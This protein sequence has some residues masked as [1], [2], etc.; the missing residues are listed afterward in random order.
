LPES[1]SNELI[2]IDLHAVNRRALLLL[3]VVLV[4][5]AGW[6][7]VRWYT[8]N[9]V[10]EYGPAAEEGGIEAAR[11]AV[12][13]APGDP[14]THWRLA[15]LEE[16][17]FGSNQLETAVRHYAEAVELSPNDY[18]LWMDYGRVLE[19]TGNVTQAETALRHATQLAPAYSYPHWYLGNLLLRAGRTNEAFSELRGVAES[20]PSLRPYV[21]SLALKVFG[22]DAEE[23]K[24]AMGTSTEL[25]A[26]LASY[27]IAGNKLDDALRLWNS[28]S[29]AEKKEQHATGEEVLKALAALKRFHAALDVAGE[30]AP[31]DK[32]KPVF[33]QFFNGSFENGTGPSGASVFGWQMTS[34]PQAQTTI[35]SDQHH[36]GGRS[37]RILY[38][39]NSKVALNSVAQLVVVE[40][41]T[42]YR[43]ECYV[44]T[45][46]LKSAGTP[47]FEIV[48]ETNGPVLG[49][50]APVP[51]GSAN[52][53]QLTID[54]ETKANTE[55]IRLRI[56]RAS[57]GQD[58]VCPIFGT[59]WYDDFNLQRAGRIAGPRTTSDPK[60]HNAG[61][62]G[63]R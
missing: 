48:D 4:L 23:I 18:R 13:L 42:Q 29:P 59:V 36:Q 25:R 21:F 37:L 22:E 9:T 28:F 32:A 6:F 44:R 58:P 3:P 62:V 41:L 46:Q 63:A 53:A 5:L 33:N 51:A 31:D 30:L 26:Q 27:F 20:T 45:D 7:A 24:N 43:F 54:F 52:W 10:A 61:T 50:S 49:T 1:N 40:P 38:R 8:G 57:C 16:K 60:T 11:S 14:V 35:D 12:R 34:I 39:S 15:Q 19:E 2:L 17:D 56:N 55:A 47:L